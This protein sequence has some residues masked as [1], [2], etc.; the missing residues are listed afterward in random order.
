[1]FFTAPRVIVGLYVDLEAPQNV[2]T[3]ALAV[4]LLGIA[5][6][7]QVFD[8]VQVAA[9]GA[10]RGLKDTR[11]PMLVA[12][13]SYWGVGLT[14]GYLFGFTLGGG[15]TGLWWGLVAGLI[16]GAAALLWRFRRL[17]RPARFAPSHATDAL[18]DGSPADGSP[19]MGAEA[20]ES[21]PVAV[22][23]VPREQ[24]ADRNAPP[25]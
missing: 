2:A 17:T 10:L 9:A 14:A 18:A 22:G 16:A 19:A 3:A 13:C 25:D 23:G 21:T 4:Q 11:V 20:P 24:A 15:P 5:A 12:L 1:L 6:V 8:G 7:F